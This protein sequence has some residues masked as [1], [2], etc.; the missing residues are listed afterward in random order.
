MGLYSKKKDKLLF[1]KNTQ[2][3]DLI[4]SHAEHPV[5]L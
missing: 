2:V 1:P 3:A 5:H 4:Q